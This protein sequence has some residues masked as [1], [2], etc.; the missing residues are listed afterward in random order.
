MAH[1][2]SNKPK[3]GNT[4]V[5]PNKWKETN[6]WKSYNADAETYFIKGTDTRRKTSLSYDGS[7]IVSES[8][9]VQNKK[10]V[11]GA[12]PYISKK[13]STSKPI[14]ITENKKDK[15]VKIST[16]ISNPNATDQSIAYD[17]RSKEGTN[18]FLEDGKHNRLRTVQSGYLADTLY[19]SSIKGDSVKRGSKWKDVVYNEETFPVNYNPIA[20]D[21]NNPK[22][23]KLRAD[24]QSIMQQKGD[25]YRS[26]NIN[27]RPTSFEKDRTFKTTLDDTIA[28]TTGMKNGKNLSVNSLMNHVRTA[29]M[30]P[31]TTSST[32]KAFG[33]LTRYYNRYK[34][35][36]PN[37]PLQHGHA[38]VFF[39]RPDCNLLTASGK[40]INEIEYNELFQYAYRHSP[41]MLSELVQAASKNVKNQFMMSLSNYISSFSLSDEYINTDTYGRTYTGYKI[42]FG[43]HDI[44]SKTAST[45]DVVFNDDRYLHIYQII[46]LWV[47]YINGVYRGEFSPTNEYIFNKILDYVGSCYYFIT[48]EDGE[49]IIFWTKYYG[50]FPSTIPSSQYSWGEGNNIQSPQLS[51]TFNY[52]FKEDFNPYSIYEFNY[53][54]KIEEV[55]NIKTVPVY[56]YKLGHASYKYGLTPFIEVVQDDTNDINYVYKLRYT[57]PGIY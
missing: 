53:N 38:H 20:Y 46:R 39:V 54:A 36:N 17:F 10:F 30:I 43:K 5:Q 1:K 28:S 8:K 22:L 24:S 49:T 51:V 14:G 12:T 57:D 11:N 19:K 27:R 34:I 41:M 2:S 4:A 31:E 45:F 26:L 23:M 47:E 52:S 18:I 56:D 16:Q 13:S 9:R 21:N 25:Q 35:P 15:Q 42:S 32:Q 37:L 33:E 50:V 55:T 44:E 3:S 7:S 29:I 48:A 40:L 6:K